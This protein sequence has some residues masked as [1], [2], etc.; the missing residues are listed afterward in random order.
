MLLRL[1]KA[2]FV[3]VC[4]SFL[5]VTGTLAQGTADIVGTVTDSTGA[6]LPGATVT[7]TNT[8]TN[9]GSSAMTGGSGDFIFPQVQ[10]GAYS[11]TVEAMGFKRFSSNVSVSAGDRARVDAKME[12]GAVTQTVEVQSASTPALQTDTSTLGSLVTQQAVED[13]PLNGRN[14]VRLVQLSVGVSE[15][16]PNATDSGTR[17]DDRRQTSAFS[18]NGQSESLN[19]QMIDGVDNNERIIG[20]IGVRP[21]VDAI[22]E[23]N[24]ST[25]MY[26]AEYG[27]TGGGVVNIITKS[28]SNA[29]HGSAYEFFRN[30]VLNANPT[31]QFPSNASGGLNP[32]KPLSNPP[33]RQNQ[34]GGSLGGAI[35]KDKTFFFVDYEGYALASGLNVTGLA[36]PTLCERGTTLLK[37]QGYTGPTSGAGIGCP[38]DLVGGVPTIPGNPGDFSDSPAISPAGGGGACAAATYGQAGGC[39]YINIS[40][41]F[42]NF[43]PMGLT[44]FSLYPLPLSQGI[45]NNYSAAP[46]KTQ[47]AKTADL[48]IDHH[49]SDSNTLFARY[50]FN[51][52]DTFTP[53]AF[54]TVYISTATHEPVAAGASG[55]VKVH[56]SGP[57]SGQ[58]L[59]G[60]TNAFQGPA[61]E[62]QQS[63]T[64]SYV[65]VFRPDLLLN[66]KANYLRSGIQSLGINANTYVSNA[67]GFPCNATQCVNLPNFPQTSG[68]A[69]MNFSSGNS[70]TS[71]LTDVGDGAA[72]PLL[73]YDSTFQYSAGLT[74]IKGNQSIKFGISLIRRRATI[75]QAIAPHGEW[76]F[77][78][79]YT[80]EPTGDL[81]MG[82]SPGNSSAMTGWRSVATVAPGLRTWE[83]SGFVQDDWRAKHWLTLNLGIRYDIFT[84]FTEKRGRISNFNQATGLVTSPIIPGAQ[85]SGPTDGILTDY[86]DIA[87][88]FGFAA[89]LKGNTVVRGGFGLSF[90]P[91]NYSSTFSEKNAPFYFLIPCLNQTNAKSQANA[92]CPAP[93]FSGVAANF[94]PATSNAASMVGKTGGVQLDQALPVPTV[95]INSVSVPAACN[96]SNV[97]LPVNA[98][99]D[100]NCFNPVTNP[101]LTISLNNSIPFHFPAAYLEQFNL[102]VQKE[103]GSGNV[104]TVGYV[105]ELGRHIERGLAINADSNPSQ[106]SLPLAAQFPWLAQTPVV[107]N[108]DI[109]SSA[110]NALQ[111]TFVRRF[112]NGLTVNVGYSWAHALSNTGGACTPTVGNSCLYD[113]P[114][115]PGNPHTVTWFNKG[116]AWGNTGNDVADRISGAVNYEIQYGKSLTG[117]PG[118]LLKGWALNAAGAWQTGLPFA[119]SNPSST[120][121]TQVSGAAAGVADQIC[122]G[123]SAHPTL[124][125]W[126][127]P[128]CFESQSFGTFGDEHPGQLMGPPQRRLDFSMFKEIPVRENLHL[129]FRAE[130]F[131]LLNVANF[132][133]PNGTLAYTG[134]TAATAANPNAHCVGLTGS[135]SYPT[136]SIS[137]LNSSSTPRQIQLALKLLF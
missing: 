110:Y 89:T 124:V 108:S 116:F 129:Q 30:K 100:P 50:S 26:S 131:N 22:Q 136:G 96:T 86:R 45:L 60:F 56:P 15:G 10:V 43:D 19:N 107:E 42:A 119:V 32:A 1:T 4:L 27:R 92:P 62:R 7:L 3:V 67:L 76:T 90:F 84:P 17:P 53:D 109:A 49:F 20:T 61:T 64:A 114:A 85:Q 93:F 118:V 59:S 123:R 120:N 21:S 14:F 28:G 95:N 111:A 128:A 71:V 38:D 87:P 41:N 133:Q 35:K 36:V 11:I 9:I 127:N 75:N 68:L 12:V 135:T 33:F 117:V 80:G 101:Y 98:T 16:A 103:I 69:G 105:G 34:Y 54:P 29:F 13:I 77:T 137:S 112:N 121:E 46:T 25:N 65:H 122:S 55:A 104:L 48:R 23:V 132:G 47:Y 63:W 126:F 51:Q 58:A 83:P 113:N 37:A 97:I 72:I 39:P 18:A 57:G 5:F 2:L 91:T 79:I 24:V 115:S 82:L 134:C 52:V 81:L 106:T 74:W 66:L 130:V 78:G 8:G 99:N 40:S 6:V 88:R 70:A 73:Q 44:M 125:Q 31:Y 102:Q 94:G